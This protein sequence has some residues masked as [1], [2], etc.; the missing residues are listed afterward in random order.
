MAEVT[1]SLE[2]YEALRSMA[3]DNSCINCSGSTEEVINQV[4]MVKPKRKPTAYNRKYSK[5]FKSIQSKY[6][7]KNGS[8]AKNGFRNCCRAANKM[9]K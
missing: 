2:E 9:C 6:K 7:L 4:P 3:H 8:W 5:A 1:L